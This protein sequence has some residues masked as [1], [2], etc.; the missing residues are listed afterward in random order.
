V[1]TIYISGG[2]SAQIHLESA[3][4]T[5][6]LSKDMQGKCKVLNNSSLLGTIKFACKHTSLFA[7]I[8]DA[9][10]V[11]LSADPFFSDLFVE[12]MLFDL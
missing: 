12:N 3:V 9:E 2:F 7:L 8:H 5:G 4:K 6:L 1:E 10:Y 11:D